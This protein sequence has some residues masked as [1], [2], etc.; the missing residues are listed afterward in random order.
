MLLA[1][2]FDSYVTIYCEIKNYYYGAVAIATLTVI[3]K[4]SGT[5]LANSDLDITAFFFCPVAS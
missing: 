2:V 1:N 3:G 5:A 4:C